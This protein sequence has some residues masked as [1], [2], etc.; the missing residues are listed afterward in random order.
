MNKI[1]LGHCHTHSFTQCLGL[2]QKM[3]QSQ[4]GPRVLK[5]LLSLTLWRKF[6][7]P[8]SRPV[9]LNFPNT[10][11]LQFHSSCCSD[12]IHKNISLLLHTRYLICDPRGVKTQ[13]L[14]KTDLD[15]LWVMEFKSGDVEQISKT[16]L[17]PC[18]LLK[19]LSMPI[20]EHTH[21]TGMPMFFQKPWHLNSNSVLSLRCCFPL[22]P[23]SFLVPHY[24]K[25]SWQYLPLDN[26][27]C[28]ALAKSCHYA[29]V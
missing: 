24:P 26:S 4:N 17:K 10:A 28:P 6:A 18:V 19:A 12:P 25:A 21:A 15:F 8:W 29:P 20:G 3:L 5:Y 22:S 9:V 1:L 27:R 7:D 13:K 11:T 14:R 16:E 2:V 23:S